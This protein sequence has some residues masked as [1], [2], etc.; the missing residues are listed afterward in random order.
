MITNL[1]IHQNSVLR[2]STQKHNFEGPKTEPC[3]TPQLILAK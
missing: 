2:G 3:G 1:M